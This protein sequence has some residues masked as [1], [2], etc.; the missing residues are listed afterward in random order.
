MKYR[1][2]LELAFALLIML[3]ATGAA[4]DLNIHLRVVDSEGKPIPEFEVMVHSHD[5]VHI[6]WKQG[7]DGEIEVQLS[8]VGGARRYQ[9]IVRAAGFAPA[10]IEMDRPEGNIGRTVKLTKGQCIELVLTAKDSRAIPSTLEPT[11]VFP[12]F[13]KRVWLVFQHRG[14]YELDLNFTSL[15]NLRPGRYQFYIAEDSPGIYV[16]IDHPGFMRAFRAGPFGK[17]ELA[18]GKLEIELPKPAELEIVVKPP[19]ELLEKLPYDVWSIEID[20]QSPDD[21][22]T[23]YP[24]VSIKSEQMDMC[25]DRQFLAPGGY[26]IIFQTRPAD[27]SKGFE[28]GRVNPAYYRDV[29]RY[30]FVPGQIEKALFRYTSYDEN[31]Y[32]GDHNVAINVRWHDGEPA[33]GLTYTLYHEDRNFGSIAI[34]EGKISDNGR[35]EINGLTGE[36]DA[37]YFTLIIEKGKLGRYLFQLLGEE[38]TRELEYKIVPL[39]G[40]M[41]PDITF[42]NIFTGQSIKFFDH[43]GKV[44][45][46]EF[47]ATWCGPCQKPMAHLCEVASE[48]KADWDGKAVLLCISIDDKKEDVIDYV[49][50]RG[51]FGVR[52]LWC[53]EGEPGFKSAGAKTYGITGV[54]T[55]VLINQSGRIVWRGHPGSFDIEANID[56]LLKDK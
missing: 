45:F 14:R 13:Q 53:E 42:M 8:G 29:R 12:D 2:C 26:W 32:R 56:K 5:G 21:E 51:W 48:R 37:S 54:P 9:I 3:V 47:W 34:K 27:S 20:R 28:R 17:E 41:A 15:T 55:A 4:S 22:T 16:F 43:R 38:K 30:S 7:K 11:V 31:R 35:I 1:R 10:I 44:L 49:S 36:E 39:K 46:V 33:A 40:D 24:L 19:K 18:D 50:S 25:I 6:P 52:H 23:G